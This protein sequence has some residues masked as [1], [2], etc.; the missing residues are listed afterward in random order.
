MGIFTHE[1]ATPSSVAPARLYKAMALDFHNLFPKIVDSIQCV[2]TI[3]GNGAAGTIKK[4]T[5]VE[6]GKSRYVLHK[7]EEVD[8]AKWVYNYS[9]IGGVGL[10]ETWEKISFETIVMEGPKEEGGSIRKVNIKYFTKGDAEVCDEVLK[11]N[12]SRAEG[13]LKFIEAYLLANPHYV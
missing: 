13:L 12:Q 2:E 6:G 5:L 9:I 1:F 11:S 3:E 10:P 4:I 7:V 8:E